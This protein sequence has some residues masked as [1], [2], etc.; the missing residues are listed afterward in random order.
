MMVTHAMQPDTAA[1]L[2]LSLECRDRVA[3]GTRGA[4]SRIRSPYAWS[5][6]GI[7]CKHAFTISTAQS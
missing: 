2:T 3:G 6:H 1:L 4:L 7:A 5:A